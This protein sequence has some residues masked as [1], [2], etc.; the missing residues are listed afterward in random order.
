LDDACSLVD[1]YRRGERN[2][3]EE[4]EACLAAIEASELNALSPWV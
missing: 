2:P 3:V 1:A 4:T